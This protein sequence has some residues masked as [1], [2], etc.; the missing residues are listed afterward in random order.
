MSHKNACKTK[1]GLDG[2]LSFKQIFAG[3]HEYEEKYIAKLL[4]F[5]ETMSLRNGGQEF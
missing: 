2:R 5:F 4:Q 1:Y 3:I